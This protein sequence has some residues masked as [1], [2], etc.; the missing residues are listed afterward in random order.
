MIA[1]G[2]VF[3][4]FAQLLMLLLFVQRE[5]YSYRF[6]LNLKDEYIKKMIF[7]S[8]PIIIGTSVNQINVLVDRTIASNIAV[9]GISA[10]SY[11][12]KL[13]GFIQGLFVAS[14]VT[15]MYPMI[16]KMAAEMNIDGI[17]ESLSE[18]ISSINLLV[19]PVT[20]GAM[21]F[22][23][24]IVKLLFGRGA[25][26]S[27]AVSMTSTALFF[28]SIGMLAFGLREVLSRIFYSMQD[29]KTPTYNAII[30]VVINIILNI[31]LSRYMAI[32][33]LALATSIS[34]IVCVLLM[35][36]S[37]RKKIGS[38]GMKRI[39]I[40]FVKILLSSIIMG[41]TSKVCF[42]LLLNVIDI[43]LA[44][45]ISIGVGALVYAILIYILKVEEVNM[46][47]KAVKVKLKRNHD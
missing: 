15:V 46:I 19:I 14:I 24:P 23:Q 10:L 26:D 17:K 40:S 11:A 34:S 33:G 2:S 9:G 5:G 8:F 21:I 16:S 41:A 31:I 43:N 45:I 13:N 3:A 38:F 27:V 37:L 39:S 36:I 28:Y 44:L 7:I 4:Q 47:V 25:F 18:S 42:E 6:S 29:T 22:A 32:A 12:S 35:F 30:A 1:I 20:V